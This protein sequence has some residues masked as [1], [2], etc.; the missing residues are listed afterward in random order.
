MGGW[1][2]GVR[3]VK[4]WVSDNNIVIIIIKNNLNNNNNSN[5]TEVEY[6]V[7]LYGGKMI[8]IYL[9]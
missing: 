9:T 2:A 7:C 5:R 4:R 3:R 6:K 8:Y 1:V